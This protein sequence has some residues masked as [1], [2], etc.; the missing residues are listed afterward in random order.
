ME[1]LVAHPGRQLSCYV[2]VPFCATRCGYCDFNTYTASQLPGMQVGE[3]VAAAL[4]EIELAR[5]TLGAGAPALSTVFFGG[6][7]PTMASDQQL[8]VVLAALRERFGLAPG[9]EVSL[10]AN[11]ETLDESRLE[12]LLAAGF[13]RLSLGMQSADEQVLATLDRHH[14]PG[15]ALQVARWA[16]AA[17]FTD[18]SLDLIYGTPGESMASWQ[19]SLEAAVSVDPEHVSAYSLIV[20]PGTAMAR[21]VRRGEL[22]APDDD[23]QADKY[24]LAERLLDAAGL[25]NYEISNWARPGHE[26]RHNLAYWHSDDWWGIGP[27]AHSH[28]DGVRWWNVKHPMRYATMLSRRRLPVEGHELLDAATRHE[29]R[30]LLELRLRDGLPLAELD[31]TERA[32]MSPQLDR[33]LVVE[34][35]GRFRLTVAGRL[36]ADAVTRDVL[37]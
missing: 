37:G 4:T 21:K 23:D 16:H 30:V 9:A 2:H 8:A 25:G 19:A 22:P 14:T 34:H 33:G 17:G 1:R 26:A 5:Q 29:E 35:D 31:E 15:R 6:G 3:Y 7:T 24:L 12:A 11:P 36:L 10:E 20:E 32:R 27:G 18:V 28:L 13:T